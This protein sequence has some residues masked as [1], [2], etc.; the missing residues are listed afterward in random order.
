MYNKT[1][2]GKLLDYFSNWQGPVIAIV[3]D[4]VPLEKLFRYDH[5]WVPPAD[6][7]PCYKPG[8]SPRDDLIDFVEEYLRV[9]TKHIAVCESR[10]AIRK[11]PEY[12][13]WGVAPPMLFYGDE[14]IYH[15]LN[16]VNANY[17]MIDNAISDSLGHWGTGVC[18]RCEHVPGGSISDDSF[19]DEIVRNTMHI[20]VSAFDDDGYLIWSPT[21]TALC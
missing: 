7:P 6:S 20:F 3:P 19:L 5:T 9:E 14:E 2:S 16:R 17:E 10:G 21:S 8:D 11:T 18:S 4:W 15:V 12:W 13:S 1:L